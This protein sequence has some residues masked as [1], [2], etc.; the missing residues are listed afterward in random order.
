MFGSHAKGKAWAYGNTIAIEE[1]KYTKLG[2]TRATHLCL[3]FDAKNSVGKDGGSATS[4]DPHGASGG[5]LIKANY[6]NDSTLIAGVLV[7]V[8]ASE[9]IILATKIQCV[10]EAIKK[11]GG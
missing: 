6:E 3:K 2:V 11:T 5:L 8:H 10:I 4:V 7:E 1:E 9:K